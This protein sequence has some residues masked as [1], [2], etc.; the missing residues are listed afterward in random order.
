M[1]IAA[2]KVCSVLVDDSINNNNSITNSQNV[3]VNS[4]N[5]DNATSQ[6]RLLLIS[7]SKVD[8][9][10]NVFSPPALKVCGVLDDSIN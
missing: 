7:K 1:A 10:E 5:N 3:L 8:T 2:L 9:C 4:V 6:H